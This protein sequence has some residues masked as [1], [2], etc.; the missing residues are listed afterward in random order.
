MKDHE[1]IKDPLVLMWLLPNGAWPHPS[2]L[3]QAE[4]AVVSRWHPIIQEAAVI[5]F[6]PA[7]ELAEVA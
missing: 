7:Q 4:H 6:G 2:E 5:L 3:E 1:K